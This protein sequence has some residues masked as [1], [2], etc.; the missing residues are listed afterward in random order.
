MVGQAGLFF[1]KHAEKMEQEIPPSELHGIFLLGLQWMSGS[2]TSTPPYGFVVCSAF[3]VNFLLMTCLFFYLFRRSYPVQ[4]L[5]ELE[6]KIWLLAVESQ[7]QLQEDQRQ[8]LAPAKSA[9]AASRS[10]QDVIGSSPIHLD[11]INLTA[12]SVSIVDNHIK[13]SRGKS[14][15]ASSNERENGLQGRESINQDQSSP[16]VTAGAM[17]KMKRKPRNY[18]QHKRAQV[19]KPPKPPVELEGNTEG[20]II[21]V[22]KAEPKANNSP[23]EDSKEEAALASED[24][25][26]WEE[27]VG[28]QELERAVL[29]LLE[30]GQV[31]AARQLQQKSAPVHL[32]IEL[33]LVEAALNVAMLSTPTVKG[34][35][36]PS[37]LHPSVIEHLLSS[38]LV[39]DISSATP[40]EVIF[41]VSSSQILFC[42]L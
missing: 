3:P 20:G 38:S 22:K 15:E 4:Q 2:F 9:M 14:V 13:N 25:L 33:L 31:S 42:Y 35:I 39:D 17:S 41:A 8:K 30:V 21:P 12:K 23:Q 29:S 18:A 5:R 34:C 36:T 26:Y 40:F 37:S 27:R 16:S 11:P 10:N 32:P 6:T 24:Q 1:L 19:D 7:V 28:E